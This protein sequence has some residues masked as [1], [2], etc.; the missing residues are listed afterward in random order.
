VGLNPQVVDEVLLHGS[1]S[2]N[3]PRAQTQ[4][5]VKGDVG[6]SE[7][8]GRERGEIDNYTPSSGGAV[9]ITAKRKRERAH[10]ITPQQRSTLAGDG[11]VP[12]RRDPKNA[13][14]A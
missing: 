12:L 10:T 6:E 7:R 14:G 11:R 5:G 13:L 1:D 3:H 2:P 8:G 4:T 9:S